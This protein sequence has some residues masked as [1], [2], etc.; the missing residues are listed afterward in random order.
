[1]TKDPE[2]EGYN[3]NDPLEKWISELSEKEVDE[4]A[5]GPGTR[6]SQETVGDQ[7]WFCSSILGQEKQELAEAF[8]K[9]ISAIKENIF[10]DKT[11]ED[12]LTEDDI[13]AFCE[14][15]YEYFGNGNESVL[16]FKGH[17]YSKGNRRI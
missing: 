14:I 11:I 6:R 1:M 13:K 8:K 12:T 2:N 9:K 17:A 10:E 15:L 3:L 7:L 4:L 5:A 16:F